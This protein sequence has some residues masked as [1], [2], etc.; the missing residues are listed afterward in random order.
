MQLSLLLILCSFLYS[1]VTAHA[2]NTS[3]YENY[4]YENYNTD[5]YIANYKDLA[6]S[7]M[8]RSGI[9]ASIKMAQAILESSS[10]NSEL[11]TKSNN[12][13]GIKCHESWV[14]RK[15]YHKDD[16]KDKKGNLI[17]SCFRSYSNVME[18]YKD[19]T[20]FLMYRKYYKKLFS[21]PKTDYKKWA[22]GL[23]ECGYATAK[24]YAQQLIR[25]I[26]KYGLSYLDYIEPEVLANNTYTDNKKISEPV[27]SQK[28]N[29]EILLVDY[30]AVT[31]EREEVKKIDPLNKIGI[32]QIEFA[33]NS[34]FSSST[35]KGHFPLA[36]K[37]QREKVSLPA[38][39]IFS[40]MPLNQLFLVND[41]KVV[42]VEAGTKL[43]DIAKQQNLP[44]KKLAK[45]NELSK[46]F[47]IEKPF[48]LFLEEKRTHYNGNKEVY[49]YQG[50]EN[51]Y[52]ISQRYGIK[53]KDLRQMNDHRKKFNI[54]DEIKLR[55]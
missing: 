31:S 48:Y 6:V 3:F 41:L 12:H 18:S 33:T 17:P 8:W 13:F 9:P 11:A 49:I 10:G 27:N 1:S 40:P 7:E 23:K 51:L 34:L 54:G 53:E 30:Y 35:R 43:A 37:N 24:D 16:E 50:N 2:E 42:Y 52:D 55:H 22:Y 26:E 29:N 38:K 14:G 19:H 28:N 15:Y 25:I 39:D 44:L 5:Q 47:I 4:L 21:I 20:D 32:K 45:Y 46:D 36:V